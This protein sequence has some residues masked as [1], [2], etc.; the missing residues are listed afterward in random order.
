MCG[1]LEIYFFCLFLI[2]TVFPLLLFT[3]S[4]F[5]W[6]FLYREINFQGGCVIWDLFCLTI[7]LCKRLTDKSNKKKSKKKKEEANSTSESKLN[8]SEAK[9][10]KIKV[11]KNEEA[12]EESPVLQSK[13]KIFF[14]VA[15]VVGATVNTFQSVWIL[16]SDIIADDKTVKKKKLDKTKELGKEK[17]KDKETKKKT[18]SAPKK[19]KGEAVVALNVLCSSTNWLSLWSKSADSVT[20]GDEEEEDTAKKKTKKKTTKDSSPSPSATKEKKSK[21]KGTRRKTS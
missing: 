19:K 3:S 1:F 18:K 8:G 21:S 2:F 7:L 5:Y 13:G 16:S 17:E 11:K 12:S 6:F 10:K 14:G 20:D 9:I 4:Y 15:G